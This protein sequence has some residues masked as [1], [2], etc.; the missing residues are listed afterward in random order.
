MWYHLPLVMS[1]IKLE[2]KMVFPFNS[3]K[4]STFCPL[5]DPQSIQ[6]SNF[7]IYSTKKYYCTAQV[8][9]RNPNMPKQLLVPIHFD[10]S[11]GDSE[12]LV[13]AI[14]TTGGKLLGNLLQH[15]QQW[16]SCLKWVQFNHV[17]LLEFYPWIIM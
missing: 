13:K 17:N 12:I 8:I 6:F 5:L 1:F 11:K 3:L 4:E 14:N 10:L 16:A 15:I 9:H 2:T 7:Y